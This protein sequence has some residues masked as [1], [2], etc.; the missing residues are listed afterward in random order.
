MLLANFQAFLA[1]F[2]VAKDGFDFRHDLVPE[3]LHDSGL[4]VLGPH[5]IG[6]AIDIHVPFVPI[7]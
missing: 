4:E 7:F 1:S 6:L 3:H 2:I 5:R